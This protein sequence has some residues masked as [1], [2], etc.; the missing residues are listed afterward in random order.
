MPFLLISIPSFLPC[1]FT[2]SC[3][4][5]SNRHRSLPIRLHRLGKQKPGGGVFLCFS[6]GNGGL[7]PSCNIIGCHENITV[8]HVWDQ[9]RSYKCY[10]LQS[11]L[12]LRI[13]LIRISLNV[14]IHQPPLG[15][16]WGMLP[17][18][19]GIQ[20]PVYIHDL[21]CCCSSSFISYVAK[22]M[23]CSGAI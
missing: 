23:E 10:K 6:E 12:G 9:F 20:T 21:L 4:L 16:N 1:E 8:L 22:M 5:P 11:V 13:G 2:T 17:Q 19:G 14:R 7:I 3:H 18:S 15:P